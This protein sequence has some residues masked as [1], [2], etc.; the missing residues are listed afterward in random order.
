MD[1]NVLRIK[2]NTMNK[3][4][5]KYSTIGLAGIVI[6]FIAS[7]DPAKKYEKQE[8]EEIDTY[9]SAHSDQVFVRKTSGLYYYESETGTGLQAEKLDTAYVYYTGKF[10]NGNTFDTNIGTGN[11]LIFLVDVGYLI[12][13]FDEGVTYM[14]TGGKSQFLIPSYLGYGNTGYRMPAFTPL[15]FEVSLVKLGKAPAR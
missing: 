11:P 9:L 13:G 14:K 10:L 1:Y 4:L 7:C 6:L 2:G 8:Q 3:S 12:P 5:K 15:L